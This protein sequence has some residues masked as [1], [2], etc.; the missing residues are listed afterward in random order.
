MHAD[1]VIL[2]VNAKEVFDLLVLASVLR[3]EDLCTLPTTILVPNSKKE[4]KRE[5]EKGRKKER[6]KAKKGRTRFK[7]DL[8]RRTREDRRRLGGRVA[9]VDAQRRLADDEPSRVPIRL[10]FHL[11]PALPRV[12]KQH[13]STTF[14]GSH[15]AGSQ[16]RGE[17]TP[18]S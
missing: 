15:S 11:E 5:R 2:D 17:C 4:R 9:L 10:G 1:R 3:V 12:T 7:T 18:A 8:A 13:V 16:H 14:I 6:K